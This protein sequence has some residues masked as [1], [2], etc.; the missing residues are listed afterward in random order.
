MWHTFTKTAPER[1]ASTFA[2]AYGRGERRPL[3]D[4]LVNRLQDFELHLN[5]LRACVSAITRIVE[6][7]DRMESKQEDI[8][9]EL[10]TK[11]DADGSMVD[12][13]QNSQNPPMEELI[14]L[15]SSRPTS[16]NISAIKRGRP[17]A[18]GNDNGK[19]ITCLALWHYLRDH[20]ED[21]KKWHKK[22][23]SALQT[24]IKELQD[25]STTKV[26]SSKRVIAPVA[27]DNQC[28]K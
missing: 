24:W 26:K 15:V 20:G 5:P 12:E 11:R 17:P 27:V 6:K 16:S 18:R 9:D 7:L 10:S 28:N 4:D 13:D 8:I 21:M 19:T 25:K 23:T 22:P 2:A 14:N 1:Y 3:I